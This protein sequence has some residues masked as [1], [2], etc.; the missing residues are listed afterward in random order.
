MKVYLA[1]WFSSKLER[2]AHA[3]ELEALGIAVTS[4]WLKERAHPTSQMSEFDDTYLANTA[5]VDVQDIEDADVV[6]LFTVH[7]E[8]GPCHRRGGRHFE[9]GL[10]VGLGKLLIICGPRENVFHYLGEPQIRQFDTWE[11]VKEVLEAE[12]NAN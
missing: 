7:P 3:H 6:V 10:A 9:A 1:S 5:Q 12:A 4:R 11:Q 8:N 2:K